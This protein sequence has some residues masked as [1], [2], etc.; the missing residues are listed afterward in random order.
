MLS[1]LREISADVRKFSSA[2]EESEERIIALG[3]RIDK[4][5]GPE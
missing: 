2:M 1:I 3:S 5:A 4:M